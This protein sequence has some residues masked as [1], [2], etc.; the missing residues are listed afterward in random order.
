MLKLIRAEFYKLKKSVSFKVILAGVLVYAVT[1]I[2][3]IYTGEFEAS[4]GFETL[5]DS[6]SFWGR[7]LMLCGI[8]AGLFL[9]GDFNNRIFYS[10]IAVG[11]NRRKILLAKSFVYWV[12]CLIIELFYQGIEFIY[13][14]CTYGFGHSLSSI[15]LVSLLKLEFCYLLIFSG[16]VSICILV[17]FCFKSVF[18]VTGIQIAWIMF[19][20][21]I[22]STL[23]IN[24]KQ[25]NYIYHNSIFYKINELT[26]SLYD[27]SINEQG[28]PSLKLLPIDR[29]FQILDNQQ[30]ISFV[31]ISV[32]TIIFTMFISIYI[33]DNTELK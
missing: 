17:S 14:T 20:T 3:S 30:Y 7:C 31:L 4:N 22:L 13:M 15:Q 32:F 11:N 16:F 28:I 19:G 27:V 33:F 2:Y 26:V 23:A 12:G 6:F 25:V 24:S 5:I 8:F 18:S 10:E 29:I 1:D 9:A 21:Q